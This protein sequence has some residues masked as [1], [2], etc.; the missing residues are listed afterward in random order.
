MAHEKIIQVAFAPI[1]ED[2]LLCEEDLYENLD[3][4]GIDYVSEMPKLNYNVRAF[5]NEFDKNIFIADKN[6]PKA[7]IPNNIGA[8]LRKVWKTAREK[9]E[10]LLTYSEKE[11]ETNYNNI[12]ST[13]YSLRKLL[14][15]TTFG[16]TLFYITEEGRLY[17][18][19]EFIKS[20]DFYK[21]KDS[22][23]KLYIGSFL[24][25]HY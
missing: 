9:M 2:E 5:L 8:Y 17:T 15:K 10:K 12:D 11:Y 3:S 20:V 16:D 13:I 4:F 22:E 7:V 25:Y 18:R 1:P 6:D 21:K 23:L 24:D 14:G 19:T